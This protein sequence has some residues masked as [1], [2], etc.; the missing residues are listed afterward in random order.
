MIPKL[1]DEMREAIRQHPGQPVT[2]EDD[3]TRASYVLL[4]LAAYQ[5]AQSLFCAESLDITE[6][7]AAQSAA[8]GASGW[9]DPEMD[10][11]ND[12]DAHRL[13]T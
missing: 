2:V 4:P 6:T 5:R 3:L 11:Y 10:V 8:A 7:Y 9:D 1:T 12:Y 13:Q